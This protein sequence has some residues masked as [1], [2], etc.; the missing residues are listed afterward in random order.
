MS[1]ISLLKCT[2]VLFLDKDFDIDRCSREDNLKIR[3]ADMVVKD[4]L[5]LKNRYD[6]QLFVAGK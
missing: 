3:M 5:I 6:A 1:N 2:N 4:G